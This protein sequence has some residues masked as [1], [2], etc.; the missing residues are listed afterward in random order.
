LHYQ[1]AASTTTFLAL[2]TTNYVLT[3][4]ATAPQYVAQSSLSVGSATTAGSVTNSLTFNNGGAGAASGTTFNG[5]AAQTISY[6]TIGAPSTTGTNA[7]GTWG[8][9][10]S[11][12]AATATSATSATTATNATNTAITAN[13]TDT[14][15]YLTFVSATSG[16]LPQLVNSSITVNPSKGTITGGIGGGAF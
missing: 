10:I 8:I 13:S 4:G 1:S 14:A 7:S 11:G 3:A 6:N 12:N 2:G 15:D 9:S 16:N 5:S